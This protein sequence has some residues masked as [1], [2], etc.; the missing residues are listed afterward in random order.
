MTI[1]MQWAATTSYPIV[2]RLLTLGYHLVIGG[3]LRPLDQ[4]FLTMFPAKKCHISAWEIVQFSF[5]YEFAAFQ[6]F[7]VNVIKKLTKF[8]L[9][10][11]VP[12]FPKKLHKKLQKAH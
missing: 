10:T 4:G 11:H 1:V 5:I 9:F 8:N 12:E 2:G 3:S 6:P 7:S